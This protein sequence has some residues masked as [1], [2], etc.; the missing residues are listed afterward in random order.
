MKLASRNPPRQFFAASIRTDDYAINFVIVRRAREEGLPHRKQR[1][2]TRT[3]W[4]TSCELYGADLELEKILSPATIH[5][6][7]AHQIRKMSRAEYYSSGGLQDDDHATT[8]LRGSEQHRTRALE[9]SPDS[10]LCISVISVDRLARLLPW[11]ASTIRPCHKTGMFWS[12]WGEREQIKAILNNFLC[13]GRE[14]MKGNANTPNRE[15]VQLYWVISATTLWT[16]VSKPGNVFLLL[17][18][19]RRLQTDNK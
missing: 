4:R 18:C 19:T 13:D 17:A 16:W 10:L 2:L 3:S 12:T 14:L 7:A 8:K 5:P 9:M 11:I 15:I 6:N 1:P